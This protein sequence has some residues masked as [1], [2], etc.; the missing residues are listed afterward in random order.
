M[1][2]KNLENTLNKA[3]IIASNHKHEYATFE[4][5]LLALLDD[6][7]ALKIWKLSK[8]NVTKIRKKLQ[9]YITIE[10]KALINL[11]IIDARPSAGFQKIIH[12][13]AMQGN[14]NSAGVTGIN[15]L[16]ELFLEQDSVALKFLKEEGLTRHLVQESLNQDI[17]DLTQ[18]LDLGESIKFTKN[19]NEFDKSKS[20]ENISRLPYLRS[21]PPAAKESKSTSLDSFCVNLNKRAENGQIDLLIGRDS[22]VQR[23]IEI[24]CRRQKNNPIL[25]GEPGV[26][27]TAIAEGL[28]SRI[29]RNEVPEFLSKFTI[30]S[31][32]VGSL[33]AGTR[34]RGDFEERIKSLLSE[35]KER[36]DIIIFIDEIHTIIGAGST[37][38]ASL[39]ASNLIKPSLAR[40]EIRC[41]GSTT[42]KEYNKYFS[43][44]AALLRRFQ[45]IVVDEPN[46]EQ[47]MGILKGL[48]SYYE[49]HHGVKYEQSALDSAV[50][51]SERYIHD[52]HLPDKAIDLMDE[53]GA[54]KKVQNDKNRMVRS[55][56]IEHIVS[57]I[58]H[59]PEI[60]LQGDDIKKL[61]K[62]DVNL[63]KIIFGQ[64]EAIDELCSSVKTAKAGLRS[65]LKPIGCYFFVGPTGSGKTELAKQLAKH[66]SMEFVRF[67]MSEYAESHSVSRLI[68]S[69]PGYAGHD[70]GGLLTDGICKSPFSVVLFDEIEKA[71]QEIYNILLQIMDY[72]ML[73]DSSGKSVNFKHSI[74]ILTANLGIDE[75]KT[76][77]IGFGSV[78]SDMKNN[79]VDLSEKLFSPEFRARLDCIIPF[80]KLTNDVISKIIDKNI[81]ELSKQLSEKNVQIEIDK[82]MKKHLKE[83][84]FNNHKPGGAR[85]LS[86]LIDYE[87]KH[88]IADEVLFGKLKKG[89]LVK[90]KSNNGKIIFSYEKLSKNFDE[91]KI[92]SENIEIDEEMVG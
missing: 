9:H 74:I 30:F 55:K 39:D 19:N 18:P 49:I 27:K 38:T 75:K 53:A 78:D 64:D 7:D 45:K 85:M 88:K 60:N 72:G 73:T 34:Y 83:I 84:C 5:L 16:M 48:Q 1:L 25:V 43:K 3:L 17:T 47:T 11:D 24:L 2:T 87:I 92:N 77:N 42:F 40:G 79:A 56:D 57:K 6:K 61:Q 44:D 23:T 91:N 13:A 90:V 81:K 32:D 58:L 12:R 62:L 52:R 29:V 51:L 70:Q 31:L 26:G 36:D 76:S 22:E 71:H 69:P 41:I 86:R 66:T 59:I 14:N 50:Y 65:H 21:G 89:G 63:K 4:H 67:D 33:V 28:A 54:F 37:N 80:N 35:I 82:S 10:L 68:G 46:H 20:Q 8:I 15:I